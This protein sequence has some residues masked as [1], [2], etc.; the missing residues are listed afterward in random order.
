MAIV[1]YDWNEIPPLTEE[2]KAELLALAERPDEEID[3]SDIPE[4]TDEELERM[5]PFQEVLSE[6]RARQKHT[7]MV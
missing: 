7:T 3:Y 2:R 6:W 1:R 5:R 4:L